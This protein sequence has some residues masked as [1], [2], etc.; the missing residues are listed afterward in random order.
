MDG[1]VDERTA[2]NRF[3]CLEQIIIYQLFDM[4]AYFRAVFHHQVAEFCV[5]Q[6]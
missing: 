1:W 2:K 4:S 5:L 3:E 6:R